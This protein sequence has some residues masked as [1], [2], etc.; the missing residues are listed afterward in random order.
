[1]M[2]VDPLGR[3]VYP[4]FLAGFIAL[5]LLSLLFSVIAIYAGYEIGVVWLGIDPGSF[6]SNMQS[7][8]DFRLDVVSG[9]IKSIC[10]GFIVIWVALYQGVSCTPT[11]EGI[12]E[13]T[14]R[15]VVYASLAV[16]GTDFILTAFMIGGW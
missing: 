14:T 3:V 2:G 10:F 12:S 15:S 1:M 4:R 11:S 6:W 7:A 8:V 16:L 13:A 5:P 9:M